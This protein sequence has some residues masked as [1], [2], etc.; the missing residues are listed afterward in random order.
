[1]RS[2]KVSPGFEVIFTLI[3]SESTRVPP[4]TAE[5]SPPASRITGA[6]SPVIADSSTEATPSMTSPSPGTSS[7]RHHHDV[8]GT[9]L[10]TGNGFDVARSAAGAWPRSQ[11]PCAACRLALCRGPSAMASAKFAN[12]TVNQSQSVICRLKAKL[13]FSRKAAGRDHAADLDHEHDRILHHGARIELDQGIDQRAP[14]DFCV[15]QTL[16]F[17]FSHVLA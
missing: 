10:R 4:V 8:A 9:Q 11:P 14:D 15:P 17:L 6:D 12:S 13:C 7:P 3:W 5:R 16:A 2:R 1:M